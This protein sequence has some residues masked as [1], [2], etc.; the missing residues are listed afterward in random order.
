MSIEAGFPESTLTVSVE[1]TVPPA[2]GVTVGGENVT[3][4][5]AGNAPVLRL[6]A[7]L[8]PPRDAM[9]TASVV[10]LPAPMVSI[11]AVKDIE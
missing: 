10:E 3:W 2:G 9:V 4:I 6:T 7:E 1:V 8:N 11:P 5:P